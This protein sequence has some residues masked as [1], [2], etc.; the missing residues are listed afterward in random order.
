MCRQTS[1]SYKTVGGTGGQVSRQAT[2]RWRAN[3]QTTGEQ[4]NG[5]TDT[6]AQPDRL[7][8]GQTDKR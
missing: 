7:S 1:P 5:Q 8:M 3:R 2:I 6:G 4:I